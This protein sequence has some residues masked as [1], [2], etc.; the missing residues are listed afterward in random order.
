MIKRNAIVKV[1]KKKYAYIQPQ[2]HQSSKDVC[3][4]I[5]DRPNKR[6]RQLVHSSDESASTTEQ[7]TVKKY[8]YT[9]THEGCNNKVQNQ[10]VCIKHGAKKYKY[11]C[12]HESS[13]DRGI[14]GE[15]RTP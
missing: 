12:T 8:T 7:T 14:R 1:G 5:T 2:R 3:T 6:K 15:G 11:T 9:C 10:G 4:I 13:A